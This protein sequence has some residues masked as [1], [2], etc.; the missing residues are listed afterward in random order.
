MRL[1][2]AF[3]AKIWIPDF[4]AKSKTWIP[5][6]MNKQVNPTF[7]AKTNHWFLLLMPQNILFAK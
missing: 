5:P 6:K 7:P 1:T 2:P 4:H 3:P